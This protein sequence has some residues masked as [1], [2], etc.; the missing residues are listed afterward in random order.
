[1]KNILLRVTLLL[2]Y[3]IFIPI[4]AVWCLV[5]TIPTLLFILGHWVF[6]GIWKKEF[7]AFA[8]FPMVVP[9]LL[10]DYLK[11]EKIIK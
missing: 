1:M 8:L 3:L 7:Y 2:L 9:F 10:D 11:K 6:V 5:F 4:T